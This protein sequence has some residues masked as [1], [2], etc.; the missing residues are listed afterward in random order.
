MRSVLRTILS[1]ADLIQVVGACQA[2][3]LLAVE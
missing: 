1:A 2:F 3:W